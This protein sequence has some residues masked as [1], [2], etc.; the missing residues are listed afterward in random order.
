[1]ARFNEELELSENA[2]TKLRITVGSCELR[3]DGNEEFLRSEV[4]KIIQAVREMRVSTLRVPMTILQN[5]LEES[6]LTAHEAEKATD[7]IKS[8]LAS[9]SELGEIDSLRLQMAMD[10]M[11]KL[12]STLSN[13][14]KKASETA[15]EI[16]QN[17]K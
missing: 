3:F 12:M 9:M 17:L 6:R 11:S 13:L 4:A 14:L 5:G 10:R 7:A 8:D 1:M 15:E 16:T 2:T